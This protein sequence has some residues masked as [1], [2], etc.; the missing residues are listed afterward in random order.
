MKQIDDHLS[1]I[2]AAMAITRL[3][4]AR[5]HLSNS[6]TIYTPSARRREAMGIAAIDGAIVRLEALCRVIG[7]PEVTNV[8]RGARVAADVYTALRFI[9]TWTDGSPTTSDVVQLFA[10]SDMS[11]G[12]LMRSDIKWSIEEDSIWIEEQLKLLD[13]N[14]DV[15]MSVEAVR[16]IWTSG[17]FLGTS[18]RMALLL[19]PWILAKGFKCKRP[20]YGIA[21][22]VKSNIDQLRDVSQLSHQWVFEMAKA[23]SMGFSKEM[24]KFKDIYAERTALL[25]LCP[26][27]RTS[28]SIET[29]IDFI[30]E[31]PLFTTKL[32]AEKL[33]IT[34]RGA[35]IVIDKLIEANVIEVDT[36]ARN[37]KYTCRRIL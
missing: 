13:E 36:G 25:A 33:D 4:E 35:K 2:D 17:R 30:F 31:H 28:S 14:P 24:Q 6:M 10:I 11:S 15:C 19:A 16:I 5:F 18:R 12:R 23:M 8:E 34:P 9:E 3:D 32:L 22:A 21:E 20:T 29:A 26:P 27:T 7:D 37:R 1:L